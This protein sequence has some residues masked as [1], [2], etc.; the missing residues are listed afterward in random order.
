M[1]GI[2]DFRILATMASIL[3][4]L[5]GLAGCGS[6]PSTLDRTA[7]VP[8]AAGDI[9]LDYQRDH[10]SLNGTWQA[11]A[12]HGE[13]DVFQPATAARMSGWQERAIPGYL[14]D[15]GPATQPD[16]WQRL[17][18]VW[19]RR[20]FTLDAAH[21]ARDAV[22]K[23]N[24][25]RFGA[26][27]W[28]NGRK[29]DEHATVGPNTVMIPRD[30]LRAG[31][32]EIVLKIPGWAG[33]PRSARARPLV[34]TGFSTQPWGSKGPEIY[35]DIWLEF[36]DRA[37]VKWALSAPDIRA[38]G[39]TFRIWLDSAGD[40]PGRVSLAV[41]V[42]QD[43]RMIGRGQM[44][45]S[46]TA[47]PVDLPVALDRVRLW[48]PD[49]PNVCRAELTV[50]AD[51]AVCD[52]VAFAFGMRE[53]TIEKGRYRL[54]GQPI[55]FRGSNLLNEWRR[56]SDWAGQP[57]RVKSY[58]VDDARSMSMTTFRTHTIPPATDWLD[59]CDRYGTMMLAE[60]PV[61]YNG[62]SMKF[63][64]QEY[65][66]FHA[67]AL[68]D[69]RDWITKLWNHPSVMM[70]VISNESVTDDE[71]ESGPYWRY[72]KALDPTRPAMRTAAETPEIVD[73]HTCGNFLDDSE[74]DILVDAA[75]RSRERDPGRTLGNS[76]YMNLFSGSGRMYLKWLGRA[77]HP[78]GPLVF[79]EFAME[80][81]EAFRRA[82]YD[83]IL[84]YMYGGWTATRNAMHNPD[85]K[86]WRPGWPV[87]ISA[88]LH[89][90]LSPVLASLDLY[91]RNYRP[92]QSVTT[93]AMLIN[94]LGLEV[95]A[96]L[97]LYLTPDDPQFVPDEDALA[98]GKLVSRD[99]LMLKP[100]SMT[101][102]KLTWQVPE[103]PGSYFLAAV[104]RRPDAR[105]VVSQ[106][107]V[108]S[109]PLPEARLAGRKVVLLGGEDAIRAWLKSQGAAVVE[110]GAEGPLQADVVLVW[111]HLKVNDAERA[112]AAAI[113]EF[114]KAGGRLVILHHGKEWTWRELLDFEPVE[115]RSS[116]AFA[117]DGTRHRMLG[118]IEPEW[119]KRWNGVAEPI[120]DS[121]IRGAVLDSGTKLLWI[122][123]PERVCALSLPLDRGEVLLTTLHIRRRLDPTGGCCDPAAERILLNLLTP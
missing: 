60:L 95:A 65:E 83:L 34:P 93:D 20:S 90:S 16:A 105:P 74:G 96:T 89:S 63:T 118:G 24:G 116:R 17:N 1:T 15:R 11:L 12:E 121:S 21:A 68:A 92:G 31:R 119:L 94:E 30:L 113:L 114:V 77:D 102:H 8:V 28:V 54:N 42:R 85:W 81:T 103:K 98:A 111:D 9:A 46:P 122:D 70:W 120:A 110:A 78:A 3:A 50:S 58:L 66:V 79:A 99:K 5:L 72:V 39:A 101:P 35:D 44:S 52:S 7:G 37:Y 59:V 40:L 26:T 25:I 45:V 19:A 33:L 86:P 115:G 53:I 75:T 6:P 4:G 64:P 100:Y 62:Y 107:V 43:G 22:L 87:P 13:E 51:G 32:N 106:R 91:D 2:I 18:S 80:H 112:R 38:P 97:E 49:E 109:I 10:L 36:Y 84:P 47:A 108:R 76:E 67:H 29:L 14:V 55:S 23:H 69:A 57:G 61:L 123:K 48:S 82:G 27:T 117:F 104:I 71:W 56:R 41:T 88:A 73:L